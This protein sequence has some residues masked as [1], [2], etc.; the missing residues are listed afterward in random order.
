MKTTKP[1]PQKL[2]TISEYVRMVRK[3]DE[4]RNCTPQTIHQRNES[5]LIELVIGGDTPGY[6]IDINKYPPGKY[7]RAKPG[8]KKA[9]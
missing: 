6:K 3:T 8:P 5:K 9:T 4:G 1:K 7:K 2:V